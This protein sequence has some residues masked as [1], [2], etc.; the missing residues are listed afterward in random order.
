MADNGVKE[1]AAQTE[2]P[3]AMPKQYKVGYG[4]PPK[5]TQFKPGQSGNP[6][7]RTKGSKNSIYTC[8]QRELNSFIT[9]TDGSKITKEQGFAR[10]LTNKALRG[11]IQSQ[12]F[13]I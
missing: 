13:I 8:V 7:G 11:D 2:E 6:K 3:A 1:W 10:Q 5:S 9:L 12:K 4:K